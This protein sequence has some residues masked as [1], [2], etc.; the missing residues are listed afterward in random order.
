MFFTTI[1]FENGDKGREP[2]ESRKKE[3]R[4]CFEKEEKSWQKMD[5]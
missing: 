1:I 5:L 3:R 2:E 4:K